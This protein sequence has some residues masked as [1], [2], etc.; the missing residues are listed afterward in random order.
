MLCSARLR[1]LFDVPLD[2]LVDR[3][4]EIVLVDIAHP[5]RARPGAVKCAPGR[6]GSNGIASLLPIGP[7]DPFPNPRSFD[8]A[9]TLAQRSIW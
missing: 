4:A 2:N 3:F 9:L 8:L 6:C 5:L 1:T 7:G